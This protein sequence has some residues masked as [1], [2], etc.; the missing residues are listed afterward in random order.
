MHMGKLTTHVLN[1]TSGMPAA[2]MRVELCQRPVAG[3]ATPLAAFKTNADGRVPQ[4]LLEGA[5]LQTG[6]YTLVFHVAEYFRTEGTPL[7]EPPF[8]DQV[9]IDFGISDPTQNYHVPLL[10]TPWSYST[11]RGS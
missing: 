9:N 1:L 5:A 3:A 6:C 4:P 10:V 7:A 8:L 2:G 11:Y